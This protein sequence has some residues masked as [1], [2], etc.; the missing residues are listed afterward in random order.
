MG[1]LVSYEE[2]KGC[3]NLFLVVLL[4]GLNHVVFFFSVLYN[5]ERHF[6]ETHVGTNTELYDSAG[7]VTNILVWSQ[8]SCM[9]T[10]I[11]VWS[12]VNVVEKD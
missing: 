12:R 11:L 10:D 3:K 5:L 7:M 2:F 1:H 9:V 8:T 6:E 4:L